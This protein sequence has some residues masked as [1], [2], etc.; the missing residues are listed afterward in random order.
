MNQNEAEVGLWPVNG[1]LPDRSL[2]N[3]PLEQS[4]RNLEEY[5]KTNE[6]V[7]LVTLASV[8]MLLFWRR[9]QSTL[10]PL[11]LPEDLIIVGTGKRALAALIDLAPAM[12]V[13]LIIYHTPIMEFAEEF[14]AAAKSREQAEAL[15][16]PTQLTWAWIWCIVIYTAYCTV[17]ELLTSAT[18]GKRLLGFFIISETLEPPKY[19]QILIRNL[20][21]LVELFPY[22]RI[23]PFLLVIFFSPYSQRVGDL[24]ARTIAVERRQPLN[25]TE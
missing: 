6:L 4:Y 25:I 8:L 14:R 1:Q 5:R 17:F 13:I 15:E 19:T 11:I 22:L 23:W 16:F 21:R 9:Q 24:L 20:L 18:P 7:V 12:A 2:I 10:N 3:V